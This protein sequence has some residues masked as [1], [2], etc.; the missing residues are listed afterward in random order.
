[1]LSNDARSLILVLLSVIRSFVLYTHILSDKCRGMLRY[2]EDPFL[3][4]LVLRLSRT[5]AHM[6]K[7]VCWA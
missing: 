1:M 4:L 5:E 6:P 2:G 7:L 3:P